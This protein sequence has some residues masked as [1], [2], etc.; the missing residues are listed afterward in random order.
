MVCG[1]C[2]EMRGVAPMHHPLEEGEELSQSR[3]AKSLSMT[4]QRQAAG[5]ISR[6]TQPAC[7]TCAW[8]ETLR[9]RLPPLTPT[10]DSAYA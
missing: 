10:I 5:S 1:M 2:G 4:E 3:A 9:E 8:D 7:F 6:L